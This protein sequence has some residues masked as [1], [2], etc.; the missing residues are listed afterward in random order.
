MRPERSTPGSFAHFSLVRDRIIVQDMMYD[1]ITYSSEEFCELDTTSD[2]STFAELLHHN[3]TEFLRW[4]CHVVRHGVATPSYQFISEAICDCIKGLE[5]IDIRL[6]ELNRWYRLFLQFMS[7]NIAKSVTEEISTQIIT[8]L[9]TDTK[10][11][12]S[13]C[14]ACNA[15][16][17]RKRWLFVTSKGYFGSGPS[18]LL[19]G[20]VN[21]LISR[22]DVPL[23]IRPSRAKTWQVIGPAHIPGFMKGEQWLDADISDIALA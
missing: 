6:D 13:F 12:E 3:V 21:S 4:K 10:A 16:S 20:D 5:I 2:L 19:C 7:K 8:L 9:D 1:S 23:L 18:A 11:M 22:V 15:L 14:L 17:Q